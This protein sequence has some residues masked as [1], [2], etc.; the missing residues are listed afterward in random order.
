MRSLP[1]PKSTIQ[2]WTGVQ[3][4]R[5]FTAPA[6]RES[7]DIEDI[8]WTV[9]AE[10]ATDQVPPWCRRANGQSHEKEG[11]HAS[12]DA[13]RTASTSSRSPMGR[14]PA[15]TL[16]SRPHVAA[17]LAQTQS[18]IACRHLIEQGKRD[19]PPD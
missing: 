7:L 9:G 18:S 17:K 1:Q 4:E 15:G 12:D 14:F 8:S 16:N 5:P 19:E 3:E 10:D 11:E 13:I 2:R 6:F